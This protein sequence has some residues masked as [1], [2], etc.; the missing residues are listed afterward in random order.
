[1]SSRSKRTQRIRR[2]VRRRCPKCSA[3]L[4]RITYRYPTN[5]MF[6]AHT[7]GELI[8]GGCV[9]Q[10]DS[11]EFACTECGWPGNRTARLTAFR[12]RIAE[13]NLTQQLAS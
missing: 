7:R 11:P 5:D 8:I 6:D 2:R 1:M 12:S 3:D 10:P 13:R 4:T 9:L